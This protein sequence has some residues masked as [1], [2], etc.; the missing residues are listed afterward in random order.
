MPSWGRADPA[1]APF[2]LAS[3]NAKATRNR[4]NPEDQ[5]IPNLYRCRETDPEH[6]K[7]KSRKNKSLLTRALKASSRQRHGHGWARC[8]LLQDSIF[9]RLKDL[10]NSTLGNFGFR[11]QPN[12]QLDCEC[13]QTFKREASP[14]SRSRTSQK[15]MDPYRSLERLFWEEQNMVSAIQTEHSTG[16]EGPGMFK[17]WG[18]SLFDREGRKTSQ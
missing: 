18:C 15:Y 2:N 9:L 4:G 8:L 10:Q 11:N 3:T 16:L 13:T 14:G 7:T 17:V 6:L 1:G 5:K 12:A